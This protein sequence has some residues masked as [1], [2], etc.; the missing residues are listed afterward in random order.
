MS[1]SWVNTVIIVVCLAIVVPALL[2]AVLLCGGFLLMP[3]RTPPTMK[4]T[5]APA[6]P[7]AKLPPARKSP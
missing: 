1:S 4:A 5:P 6:A 7:L 3:M 2:V